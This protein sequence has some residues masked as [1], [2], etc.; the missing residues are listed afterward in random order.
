M[1]CRNI[2]PQSVIYLNFVF[3]GNI[4]TLSYSLGLT[5]GSAIA[6]LLDSWL[7]PMVDPCSPLN[8]TAF[9]SPNQ[10]VDHLFTHEL[11]TLMN[12]TLSTTTLLPSNTTT[13]SSTTTLTSTLSTTVNSTAV[14]TTLESLTS[15]I[16]TVTTFVAST[17]IGNITETTAESLL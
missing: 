12:T 8:A 9:V 7:G 16:T 1:A 14:A 6:Y 3:S 13:L 10:T 17:V 4:M 15:A 5:G 2:L 11:T